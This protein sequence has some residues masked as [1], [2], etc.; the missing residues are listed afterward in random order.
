[1]RSALIWKNLCPILGLELS[2]RVPDAKTIRLLRER[3]TQAGAIDILF[4][5]FDTTWRVRKTLD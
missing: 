3:L 1:M 2:D 5:H 4:N